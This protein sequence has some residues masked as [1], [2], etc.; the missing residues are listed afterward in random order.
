MIPLALLISIVLFSSLSL[1][2][3]AQASDVFAKHKVL[4][5]PSYHREVINRSHA[6]PGDQ[7]SNAAK[8]KERLTEIMGRG[9]KYETAGLFQLAIDEYKVAE[10]LF[11]A[12]SGPTLSV[13]RCFWNSGQRNQALELIRIARVRFPDDK[14][15]LTEEIAMM[16]SLHNWKDASKLAEVQLPKLSEDSRS[17]TIAIVSALGA[18]D[19]ARARKICLVAIQKLPT[20]AHIRSLFG[21]LLLAEG[22]N[23]EAQITCQKAIALNAKSLLAYMILAQSLERQGKI[24]EAIAV[25]RTAFKTLP[26]SEAFARSYERRLRK[27]GM[28]REAFVP[29]MAIYTKR[30]EQLKGLTNKSQSAIFSTQLTDG[31][32]SA[33]TTELLRLKAQMLLEFREF[34]TSPLEEEI[35]ESKSC[36]A[37]SH[38]KALVELLSGDLY[39]LQENYELAV[40]HYARAAEYFPDSRTKMEIA[41]YLERCLGR[42]A[43]ALVWFSAAATEPA[44]IKRR[45]RQCAN[46]KR[47]LAGM[48]KINLRVFGYSNLISQL[49]RANNWQYSPLAKTELLNCENVSQMVKVIR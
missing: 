33:L 19:I 21:M 15:I 28:V 4:A 23:E 46:L 36:F 20:D 41:N 38:E 40:K 49:F 39:D 12:D 2:A 42:P 8:D 43:E 14:R 17:F 48:A 31:Q 26:F 44:S 7:S 13:I 6:T 5:I 16:A 45:A 37:D 34:R 10:S 47:D 22:K 29:L 18:K 1:F 27:N 32:V 25:N 11:P 3:S 24:A 9:A 35:E 30:F